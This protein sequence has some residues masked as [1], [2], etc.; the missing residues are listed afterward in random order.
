M[1]YPCA[2]QFRPAH[3]SPGSLRVAYNITES[4]FKRNPVPQMPLASGYT[5]PHKDPMQCRY[6]FLRKNDLLARHDLVGIGDLV[7]FTDFFQMVQITVIPAA[8]IS[9]CI[10]F[11]YNVSRLN[12]AH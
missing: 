9:Q 11:L 1:P 3:S 10:S 7:D 4:R 5:A 6:R 8:D 2:G 12:L